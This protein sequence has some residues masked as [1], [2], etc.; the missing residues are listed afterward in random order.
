[1]ILKRRLLLSVKFCQF[2][3]MRAFD[4]AEFRCFYSP[5]ERWP[6]VHYFIEPHVQSRVAAATFFVDRGGVLDT[7]AFPEQRVCILGVFFTP[8]RAVADTASLPSD[9]AV[10]SEI[11]IRFPGK[12]APVEERNWLIGRLSA[13]SL[14]LPK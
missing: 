4:F 8:R 14:S 9:L 11:L 10:G 6:D 7:S 12:A 3:M 2:L 5:A 13:N 1:M